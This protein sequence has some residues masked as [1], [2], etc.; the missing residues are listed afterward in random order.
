MK[1]AKGIIPLS[2]GAIACNA[3]LLGILY[4]N[5]AF[6]GSDFIIGLFF[7]SG[8]F[9][10][11]LYAVQLILMRRSYYR[12]RNISTSAK[13]LLHICRIIQLVYSLLGALVVVVGVNTLVRRNIR[14]LVGN[15]E[16]K[17]WAVMALVFVTVVLNM[18]IF[19]KGWRLLKL[20][21]IPYIDEVI[22]SFD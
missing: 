18:T 3:A 14:H 16:Y 22:A 2:Y 6:S 13:V 19:F 10:A 5:K 12:H 8:V 15:F 11:L 4:Y 9:I 17:F 1:E 7:G 21:K 20:V